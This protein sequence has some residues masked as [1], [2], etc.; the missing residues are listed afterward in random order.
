M[1]ICIAG[2]RGEM[3]DQIEKSEISDIHWHICEYL[4]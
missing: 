3:E 2:I 4:I 1:T